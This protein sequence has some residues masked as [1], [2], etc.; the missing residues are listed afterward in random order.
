MV[1]LILLNCSCVVEVFFSY[2]IWNLV[3]P[4]TPWVL[5]TLLSNVEMLTPSLLHLFRC[6]YLSWGSTGGTGRT[7]GCSWS[8]LVEHDIFCYYYF[9]CLDFGICFN[10]YDSWICYEA[11]FWLSVNCE[12]LFWTIMNIYLILLFWVVL[13]YCGLWEF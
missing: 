11:L 1:W 9:F 5:G 8:G 7:S 10:N 12:L 13:G 3:I 2:I 6:K 4:L